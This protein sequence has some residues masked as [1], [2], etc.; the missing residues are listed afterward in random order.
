MCWSSWKR[1][2]TLD[3]QKKIQIHSLL[4]Q[5]TGFFKRQKSFTICFFYLP[6]STLKISE[7]FNLFLKCNNFPQMFASCWLRGWDLTGGR[8]G[9]TL[10]VSGWHE[11]DMWAKEFLVPLE[12]TSLVWP[13]P[14]CFYDILVIANL[15]Q[16]RHPTNTMRRQHNEKS[17]SK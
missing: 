15:V 17:F 3:V 9:V 6:I 2:W 8:W 16:C 5:R 10:P 14:G 7:R 11:V 12:N 4:L 13:Q 1:T